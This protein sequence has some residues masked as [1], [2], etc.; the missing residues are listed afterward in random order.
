MDFLNLI[1]KRQ[2][3]RSYS[4]QPVPREALERCLEAVRL[5]PSACNSQPWHFILVESEPL[6]TELADQAFHGIYGINKFA[7]TAPV[8]VAVETERSKYL[9]RLGGQMRGIQYALVDIGI[10]CQHFDLA[11]AELGLGCCWLGW[12]DEKRVKKVLDLPKNARVDIML[13]VGYPAEDAPRPKNRKNLDSM[14][15]YR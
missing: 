3:C 9:A 10:A 7:R 12:F 5:A 13:S 4:S 8:L 1:S 2:S 14:R 15:E 11:A 6:R